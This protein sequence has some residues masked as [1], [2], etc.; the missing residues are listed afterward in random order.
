MNK[1]V[2]VSLCAVLMLGS[3]L[4]VPSAM[5][6]F[7]SSTPN[8]GGVVQEKI[9]TTAAD[10]SLEGLKINVN[11]N[12]SF[13][14]VDSD[15]WPDGYS[16]YSTGYRYTDP[17][18]TSNV[19]SGS[20]AGYVASQTVPRSGLSQA[21]IIHYF[22][23]TPYPVFAG[24]ITLEFYWN[25]LANP[26]IALGSRVY[27]LIQTTNDTGDYHELRYYLSNSAFSILNST[28]LT[29]YMWNLSI[30]N[31]NHFSRNITADYDANPLIGPA[32]PSR[33]ITYL[34]WY[35]ATDADSKNKLE[36]ALD[37]VVLS[38]GTYS[39]WVTNGD[40]ESGDGQDWLHYDSTPLYVSQSTDTTDGI[41]SL[42]MTSGIVSTPAAAVDGAVSRSYAYPIGYYVNNPGDLLVQFDWKYSRILSGDSQ[43]ATLRVR[44][45][46]E[47][48]SYYLHFYLGIGADDLTGISNDTNNI[49]FGLDGYKIRDT[50]HHA[51][52]DLYEY[53]ILF[54]NLN[55]TVDH[56]QFQMYVPDVGSQSSLLVDNFKL[57]APPTGDP[58]FE[59]DWYE[60]ASTVFAGWEEYHGSTIT[61]QRTTDAFSG[62]H[63]CNLTPYT[64]YDNSAGVNRPISFNVSPDDFLNAWWRL[65]AMSSAD[66]SNVLIRLEFNGA[67]S[68]NYYLGRG[69]THPVANTSSNWHLDVEGFN[70][71][72]MWMN[73]HRNITADAELGLSFSGDLIINN[74]IIRVRSDY[75]GSGP[76]LTTL[77]IDDIVITDGAPPVVELVEHSPVSPMY[78]ETVD[79]H[80]DAFDLRPGIDSVVINFTTNGGTSWNSLATTGTYDATIPAQPYGTVVEFQVV[81]VDG[82]GHETIDDNGG[83]MYSYIVDDDIDPVVSID[84]PSDMDELW[85]DMTINVTANDVAS[86]IDYVEFFLG[87]SFLTTDSVAP[88]S[89][90]VYLE[91]YELGIY[92]I[93][94]IAHDF[95]GN[96]ASDSINITIID[97][98]PPDLDAPSDIS[99]EEGTMGEV[100][101]WDPTDTR[102]ASYEVYVNNTLSLSGD[103]NSSS[104]LVVV[105]LDGLPAGLFN[106][107]CVV[108]DDGGNSDTDTVMVTVN[109]VTPTTTE[110]TTTEPTSPSTTPEPTD[111]IPL[112]MILIVVGGVIVLIVLVACLK[113]K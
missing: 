56:L 90:E 80:V 69:P 84:T 105:S 21:S 111:G 73:L 76:S 16:G 78:Y 50:W 12:P 34:T 7:N 83:L 28:T 45:E 88:F 42:N 9:S 85:G 8:A 94:V 53:L 30:G 64:N 82:V 113:K 67:L 1:Q 92:T 71:T 68:L 48:A 104:D 74:V 81:V 23:L 87:A 66:A 26:D 3:L 63:A 75:D 51:D 4:V 18:Y 17:A 106:Y 6:S 37:D 112:E 98:I 46:N 29:T 32:D 44:F 19:Y 39:S 40:F 20:Y 59:Q 79:I 89:H 2:F 55:G 25:T 52:L 35:T 107:T 110:P 36:F 14:T 11:E 91:V 33:R 86:G 96:I 24:G 31:W 99:F 58:G 103:W 13:E 22:G 54:G 62:N 100:I 10:A 15:G 70:T 61:N 5:T 109:A 65:D 95:E 57:I 97:G 47:T 101:E 60:S 77:I 27:L 41:Y 102:P 38:N 93:N 49:H 72:G 43:R 108:Y